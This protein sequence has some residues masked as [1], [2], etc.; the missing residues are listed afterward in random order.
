M[1]ALKLGEQKNSKMLEAPFLMRRIRIGAV[2]AAAVLAV[3][4]AAQQHAGQYDQID[5]EYGAQIFAERCVACHGERGDLMP[6]ANLRNGQ[7]RNATSDR[8][9]TAVIRDGIEGTAMVATGYDGPEL[10]ALVAY[11]R[12]I[13]T[14]EA[15]AGG[16]AIGDAGR[17]R[18]LFEGEGE[19]TTCHRVAG[20]GPR[21]A[22]S[23]A[24]VGARRTA[25]TLWRTLVDPDAA[26]LPVNRPVR[27]VT[28]DG[29]VIEGRRLNEDTFTVLLI[30]VDE[31]LVALDKTEL[32]ELTVGTESAMQS[33]AGAF[34][35]DELADLLAYLL[36]L[37]GLQ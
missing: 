37:K 10:A 20:E 28:R 29:R 23:L 33:Y 2:V 15:R 17:G 14:Y 12:N 4:A 3:P 30:T 18:V 27:A 22:P 9:L 19:C 21:F 1:G 24:S 25:A 26:M 32:S 35:D 8:E 36:S 16:I 34:D 5:I 11:L 7:Y 6:Q 31:A 13:T